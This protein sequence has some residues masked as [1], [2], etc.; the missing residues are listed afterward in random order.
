[1][2]RFRFQL[3]TALQ[4]RQQRAATQQAL[5]ERMLGALQTLRSRKRRLVEEYDRSEA[6]T[7]RSPVVPADELRALG[8]Y[9][10]AI[11]FQQEQIQREEAKMLEAIERQRKVLVEETRQCRLLERLKDRKLK[12]W[13]READREMESHAAE[14]FLAKWKGH[15]SE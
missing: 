3:E 11:Q 12:E 6:E 5:L 4:W 8:E 9:R 13:R 1:M 14:G 15:E 10:R 2:K 7:I